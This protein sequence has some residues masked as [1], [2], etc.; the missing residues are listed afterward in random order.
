MLA[1]SF[2]SAAD[3][4]ITEPQFEALKKTLVLLETA[5]LRHVDAL[6]TGA[7]DGTSFSGE[8]NMCNWKTR[9]ECGT[10]GC[11]GGTAEL[12]G[13]VSFGFI[14]HHPNRALRDLFLPSFSSKKWNEI[15]PVQAATAL[16]S[17]LTTGDA[18]WH[19]A[20]ACS[21]STR[22]ATVMSDLLALAERC[23]KATEAHRR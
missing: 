11:I 15:T 18:K 7:S 4:G 6:M 10:V 23:E 3:L 5:K 9:H 12:I 13:N 1:Q 21:V 14:Y 16:R 20:V 17:Y 22:T 2:K 19:E 8:F